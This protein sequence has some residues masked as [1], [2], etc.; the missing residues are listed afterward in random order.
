MGMYGTDKI[1]LWAP[2]LSRGLRR[3]GQLLFRLQVRIQKNLAGRQRLRR[4]ECAAMDLCI[5]ITAGSLFV[6]PRLLLHA[7]YI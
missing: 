5:C 7:S 1:L 4:R 2:R 3:C 6:G